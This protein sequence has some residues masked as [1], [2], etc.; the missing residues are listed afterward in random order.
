M[1]TQTR[2]SVNESV[3]SLLE[4]MAIW[5]IGYINNRKCVTMVTRQKLNKIFY[6]QKNLSTLEMHFSFHSHIPPIPLHVH[7]THCLRKI[8][9]KHSR[10]MMKTGLLQFFCAWTVN[11]FCFEIL[12]SVLLLFLSLVYRLVSILLL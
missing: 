9:N 2:G 12:R 6:R 5:Q 10:C 7:I 11:M 8:Q 3:I 1:V 4:E